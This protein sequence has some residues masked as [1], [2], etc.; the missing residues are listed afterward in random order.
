MVPTSST[1]DVLAPH[2]LAGAVERAWASFLL[3]GSRPQTPHDMVYASAWRT[4]DRRMVLELTDADKLPPFPAE[5]LAKF[6][7]GED[8]E[9]DLLSDL[10]RIGRDA[11]PSFTVVGQQERFRLKDRKGREVISGKV[12]ARLQPQQRRDGYPLEIKAWA[13]TLVERIETFEDLFEN[14]WTRSGGYQLLSYL[15]GSNQPYGF[16]LLDRSGLP[17]LL[18]VELDAHLDRM[19]EFLVRAE[20]VRD[21]VEAG[22]LP[23]FLDDP[24]ECKRCPFYGSV[25]N[26]PLSAPDAQV[27]TDPE[28]EADLHRWHALRDAGKEWQSLDTRIKKQLRGIEHGIAGP[29]AITGKWQKYSRLDLPD[30]VKKQHTVVDPKGRFI[31]EVEKL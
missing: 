19:E 20:R 7:R 29:F 15:Y 27:L 25:C 22:T 26:P 21:H 4:C 11:E 18:P 17:L 30:D 24:I 14:P 8:R 9:R 1:P 3:R 2:E 16:M 13:P 12:D 5:V 31:L 28:L 10:Q 6:R 23:D